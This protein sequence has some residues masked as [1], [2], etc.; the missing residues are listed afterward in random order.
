M[1]DVHSGYGFA[2]G[3]VAAFNMKDPEVG[4]R[5]GRRGLCWLVCGNGGP[6]G[7]LGYLLGVQRAAGHGVGHGWIHE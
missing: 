6:A 1:P 4:A 2:I 5:G 3:N 7:W